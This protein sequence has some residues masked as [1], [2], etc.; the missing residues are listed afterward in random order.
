MS[1]ETSHNIIASVRHPR[2]YDCAIRPGAENKL[3][4]D[5]VVATLVERNSNEAMAESGGVCVWRESK[6][7]R[8][9]LYS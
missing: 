1:T 9:V 4:Q 3:K 7:K 6:V 2:L 5:L 8:T